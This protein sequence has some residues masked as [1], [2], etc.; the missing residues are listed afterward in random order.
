M[1]YCCVLWKKIPADV[2]KQD[3]RGWKGDTIASWLFFSSAAVSAASRRLFKPAPVVCCAREDLPSLPASSLSAAA[4]KRVKTFKL[5]VIRA[6]KHAAFKQVWHLRVKAGGKQQLRIL[7]LHPRSR[8]TNWSSSNV[9]DESAEVSLF[10][11]VVVRQPVA[12]TNPSS[13]F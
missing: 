2:K 8:R 11:C 7:C 3:V 1:W 4:V 10:L 6:Q 12:S 5:D 13:E 9:L